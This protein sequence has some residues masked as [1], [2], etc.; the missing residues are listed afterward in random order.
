MDL[1]RSTITVG[2]LSQT[3]TLYEHANLVSIRLYKGNLSI[4]SSKR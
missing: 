3:A 1:Q 4:Y 2:P